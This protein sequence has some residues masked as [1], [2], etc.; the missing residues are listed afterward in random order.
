MSNQVEDSFKS[1][2]LRKA[3]LYLS[4]LG[5]V[6]NFLSIWTV[7]GLFLPILDRASAKVRTVI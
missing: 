3:E 6:Y 1:C 2:G 7:N 5:C 4:S